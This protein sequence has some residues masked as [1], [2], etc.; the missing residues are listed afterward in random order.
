VHWTP[1][2]ISPSNHTFRLP[3]LSSASIPLPRHHRFA[4]FTAP[5]HVERLEKAPSGSG[6]TLLLCDP[7]VGPLFLF[8]LD[9]P[10]VSCWEGVTGTVFPVVL[11]AHRCVA[12]S[13][14]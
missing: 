13:V 11:I 14:G 12:A 3:N 9:C 2:S 6:H 5:L 4:Q 1:I 7:F 8:L 10:L